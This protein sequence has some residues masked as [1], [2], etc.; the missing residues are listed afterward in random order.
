[1]TAFL[2]PIQFVANSQALPQE[3][4]SWIQTLN[5]GPLEWKSHTLTSTPWGIESAVE[6]L[7]LIN[8]LISFSEIEEKTNTGLCT[9]LKTGNSFLAQECFHCDTCG[10]DEKEHTGICQICVRTCHAGHDVIP[11]EN[12]LFFC[13]CGSE[14][15]KS[16]H[17]LLKKQSSM[18]SS[19]YHFYHLFL[20]VIN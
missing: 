19:P 7:V 3:V 13:N 15:E 1:M 8:N 20:F 9:Y 17:S 2:I 11:V 5:M 10:I 14:G 16:C 12:D 6:L 4:T 18:Y